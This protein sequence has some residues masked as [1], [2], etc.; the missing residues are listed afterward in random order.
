V[1]K[2]NNVPSRLFEPTAI[3][4]MKKTDKYRLDKEKLGWRN[5]GKSMADHRNALR[6]KSPDNP[7]IKK[8][9]SPKRE[10]IRT[11]SADVRLAKFKANMVKM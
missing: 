10:I 5:T 2:L 1:K 7:K 6:A 3:S 9:N 8:L 4:R 11:S